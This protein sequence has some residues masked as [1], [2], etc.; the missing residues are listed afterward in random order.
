M[1]PPGYPGHIILPEGERTFRLDDSWHRHLDELATGRW[2]ETAKHPDHRRG[3]HQPQDGDHHGHGDG[4]DLVGEV[5]EMVTEVFPPG[6][7]VG[8]EVGER[9]VGRARGR[10]GLGRRSGDRRWQRDPPVIDGC[11]WESPAGT[12]NLHT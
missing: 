8:E 12:E 1:E 7:G 6:I 3:G 4:Q 10:C 2:P 11:L 5:G 9:P